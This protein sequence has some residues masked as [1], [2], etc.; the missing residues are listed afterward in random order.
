MC[1]DLCDLRAYKGDI[2][3]HIIPLKER[4]NPFR[5]KQRI[6]NPNLV[7]IVQKELQ[8]MLEARIIAP[9]RHSY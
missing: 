6:I 5:E 3:K 8:K 1:M 9:T 7:P 2:I 4:V